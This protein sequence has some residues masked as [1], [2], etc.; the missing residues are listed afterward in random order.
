MVFLHKSCSWSTLV[1]FSRQLFRSARE[2]LNVFPGEQLMGGLFE[3]CCCCRLPARGCERVGVRLSRNAG[4]VRDSI[5]PQLESARLSGVRGVQLPHPLSPSPTIGA[6]TVSFTG[7]WT[8]LAGWCSRPDD[9]WLVYGEFQRLHEQAG[10]DRRRS[11]CSDVKEVVTVAT[12]V[13]RTELQG[14]F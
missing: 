3:I 8:L 6:T 14:P 12:P 7:R 4:D 1:L 5:C 2:L 10:D 9:D 13:G 11:Y